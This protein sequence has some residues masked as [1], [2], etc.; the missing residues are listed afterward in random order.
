MTETSDPLLD[1]L[2]DEQRV[3]AEAL[4]GPVCVLAGAG[5]GKTRAITHRIAYGVT[6]GAYDPARVMAL[7]FTARAA[8]E[9][10]GRLRALGAGAVPARTFH[11]AA[12]AQLNHFWP[13]VVGGPAPRILDYKGRLLGQAAE[14]A[15][16]RVDAP[17]L[18]DVAA[19]I[20]WRKVSALGPEAATTRLAT[21]GAPGDLTVE[22]F[23]T[24]VE[25]YEALKDERR[26]LD[27]E[28]V[29]LA[30]AGMIESE[31]SVAMQVR[32]SYRHFIV[33]EYQDV[34]P[35]QQQLLDLWLGGRRD[36]CVVGDAS[37][38][39]YSFAGATPTYLLDFERRFED[40]TVV[41][42][43]RNYRSSAAIVGLANRLMRGRAG[44]LRLE[45]VI[46][47]D[48]PSKQQRQHPPSAEPSITEYADE[49]SEARGVATRIRARIDTGAPPESIAVLMRV[50]SQSAILERALEEVGVA[51]R[52]RG[53]A[54][55]FDQPE[56]REAVH[57]LRA[58]AL[59]IAGEPLFKS[60]SDVLRGLGM[61]AQAPE[62]PGAVR[63]RWESL[64]AIARLVDDAPPG[65]TFRMFADDLRARAEAQHEPTVSAVTL[66]TLHSAKGLEWD[67][68]FIVG[69][70]EG[71]L[72][73]AYA[74]GFDA[75]D[76]ERRLLY[77]GITRARRRLELSWARR[78]GHRGE[79]EPSRFLLELGTRTRDAADARGAAAARPARRG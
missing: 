31:A 32:E 37:Q 52:V 22:Q 64:N 20:E 67:E 29:L 27:F 70:N 69:L 59:T 39:I 30:T 24:L 40:A 28:D 71:M 55:F 3:A 79:R 11:A 4:N 16:I 73:I 9:L 61:T 76:E 72:P 35:A 58:A 18:R 53:A 74:K 47:S 1:V 54:R 6:S 42:L 66:A 44:A 78:G 34:S 33:D 21:R 77:V 26:M 46:D 48:A 13:I 14:R 45:S 25:A 62:G 50:N 5:T 56:V 43:E 65:T 51:S 17:T 23:T 60:V 12:L 8:A 15:R 63:A 68:V 36:L 2:D 57:A 10:R 75:I 19:E 49:L 41:R 38:T 7:T